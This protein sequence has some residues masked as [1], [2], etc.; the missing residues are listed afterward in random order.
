MTSFL[1]RVYALAQ[2]RAE[3]GD[4]WEAIVA[5]SYGDTLT[6]N[7]ALAEIEDIKVNG[8]LV[9][10]TPIPKDKTAKSLIEAMRDVM[11]KAVPEEHRDKIGSSFSSID[12]LGEAEA[13]STTKPIMDSLRKRTDGMKPHAYKARRVS[14]SRV[15][16]RAA[17][18]MSLAGVDDVDINAAIRA[19]D[20]AVF[21]ST[22]IDY[23][24]AHADWQL[25]GH[26]VRME[27]AE[28]RAKAIDP[29]GGKDA[30]R[31]ALQEQFE[32]LTPSSEIPW[33][34]E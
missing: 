29:S 6:L 21:E 13:P 26:S 10:L 8:K 34:I 14:D 11:T 27:L 20:E 19:S 24:L 23:A 22:S 9:S 33:L 16:A 4:I 7:N 32:G 17:V 3:R 15:H 28:E 5:V 25:E 31:K 18:K 30:L 12:F 2:K 1:D